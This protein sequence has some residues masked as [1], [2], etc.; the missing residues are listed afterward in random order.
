MVTR[1]LFG[2]HRFFLG[3]DAGNLR[4]QMEFNPVFFVPGKVV[5][6][7]TCDIFLPGQKLRQARDIIE[8]V[9]FFGKSDDFPGLIL[10]ANSFSRGI[11]GHAI[12]NNDVG[13]HGFSL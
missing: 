11:A 9:F 4:F 1:P 2:D 7:Q 10:F 13:G 6:D 3:V 8:R 12:A 5:D